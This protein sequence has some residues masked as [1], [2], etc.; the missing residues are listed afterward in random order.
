MARIK[1]QIPEQTI[2]TTNIPVRI[3][4]LNYGNHVGNDALVSI[5]HEARVA[6][7]TSMQ[8]TELNIEGTSLIMADLA[9]E[10]KA[11]G[12]YGDTLQISISV[13]DITKSSFDIYYHITT[14]INNNPK[15]IAKAKTGMVCFDYANKK[16]VAIPD[17]FKNILP[18]N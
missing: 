3:T 9:V 15:L 17:T 13:S 2:F 8:Y 4:D 11:E 12:F 10:Y 7:L 1:L 5:I 6:W 16:V 18:D 14:Q